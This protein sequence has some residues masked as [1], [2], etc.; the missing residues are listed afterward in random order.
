[1]KP[2][3]ALQLNRVAVREIALRHHVRDIRVFGSVMRGED[4]EDS[5]LD[6]LVEPTSETTLMDI[7]AIRYELRKLLG[8]SVDVLTPNALPDSFRDQVLTEAVPV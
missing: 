8:I 4:T 3:Q 6:I 2:S 1:M 5:D 7:G